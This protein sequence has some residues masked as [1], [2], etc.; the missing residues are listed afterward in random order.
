MALRIRGPSSDKYVKVLH[1]VMHLFHDQEMNANMSDIACLCVLVIHIEK[2]GRIFNGI[3][4]VHYVI[5]CYPK[6]VLMLFLSQQLK[7]WRRYE[8]LR[9]CPTNMKLLPRRK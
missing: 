1:R 3:W 8:S 5:G 4:Y 9:R 6:L 7:T 2:T